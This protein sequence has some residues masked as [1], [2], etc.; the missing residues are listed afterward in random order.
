[1]G[2]G[3]V[4][5]SRAREGQ[6][7][8]STNPVSYTPALDPSIPLQPHCRAQCRAETLVPP[9]THQAHT[10]AEILAP[11]STQVPAR[12]GSPHPQVN[13]SSPPHSK[14]N[15]RKPKHTATNRSR[16]TRS[17]QIPS[18]SSAANH[19]D[20]SHST[21]THLP[22]S[23]P[24]GYTL[25]PETLTTIQTATNTQLTL[26]LNAFEHS[27]LPPTAQHCRT[28]PA[29]LMTHFKDHKALIYSSKEK[30][31]LILQSYNEAKEIQP[32]TMSAICAVPAQDFSTL[33]PYL[34]S[35]TLQTTLKKHQYTIKRHWPDHPG[36]TTPGGTDLM[37]F[38]D[39]PPPN[40]PYKL[41]SAQAATAPN[42]TTNDPQEHNIQQPSMSF[43][44]KAS[45][46][47]AYIGADSFASGMGYI[48]PTFVEANRL[49]TRPYK[50]QITLGDG[51]TQLHSTQECMVHIQIGAYHCKTWLVVFPIPEPYDI[52]LGDQWMKTNKA[53]L[54]Y[55]RQCIQILTPKRKFTLPA[56]SAPSPV[57]YTKSQPDPSDNRLLLN[58]IQTKRAQRKGYPMQLCFIQKL[59]QPEHMSGLDPPNHPDLT[60]ELAEKL[61]NTIASYPTVFGD[62]LYQTADAR[63]DMP[64]AIPIIPGS[65]I[66]NRPLYRYSPLEQQEIEKQVQAMLQQGIVEP[67]T[68]P[69]GAPV[70]LVKKPDGTWRFCVD[71]RALNAITVKNGHALPRIDDLLDKIQGAKYFSSMDLLQGFYQLPLRES[72][73]PKTAFKTTFGHYQFRVV[74]MGLSNAPS[75]FQ[76]IM[77]QIFH[78]QLNRSVLIYLD[79]ILIF[80][81]TPEEHLQHIQQVYKPSKKITSHSKPRNAT[82]SKKN[83]SS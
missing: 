1:M 68:S 59:E 31:R 58:Y 70:L 49:Q 75:V 15:K 53:D 17:R 21:S 83:S 62:K 82:S 67:S 36:A 74:S 19:P 79:D 9:T 26:D 72:D 80:S 56:V 71:Y 32:D 78:K 48:H 34:T 5:R 8:V 16:K 6:V 37:I 2:D 81:N 3:R 30:T 54:L 27:N 47:R 69:Y 60:P 63:P 44:G 50:A 18:S 51:T 33:K 38:I 24:I 41:R 28:L 73:R 66:P 12:L 42:Q 52:L 65:R 13:T 46:A 11:P 57:S 40:P 20:P 14:C 39:T 35:W 4:T 29:I 76:R 25:T 23:D 22:V 43:Q 45:G 7:P 55:S 64:E 61:H 10:R 77:N